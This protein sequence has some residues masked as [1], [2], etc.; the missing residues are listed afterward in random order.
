MSKSKSRSKNK[1]ED[2]IVIVDPAA[3]FGK[4]RHHWP[5]FREA[6]GRALTQDQIFFAE[7]GRPVEILAKE[8]VQNGVSTILVAGDD[9]TLHRV[10]NAIMPSPGSEEKISLPKIGILPG[11]SATTAF[12]SSLVSESRR[13]PQMKRI[14]RAVAV[15]RRGESMEVDLGLAEFV[16]SPKTRDRRYFLNLASFGVA[17]KIIANIGDIDEA[18]HSGLTVVTASIKALVK[19]RPEHLRLAYDGKP[20]PESGPILNFF[21]ANGSVGRLGMKLSPESEL[22][23]G[24]LRSVLVAYENPKEMMM[25]LPKLWFG[26]TLP[27]NVITRKAKSIQIAPLADRPRSR[28]RLELD[29]VLYGYVPARFTVAQRALEFLC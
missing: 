12:Y 7:S 9:T 21:V 6:F 18:I 24:Y 23:D 2:K 28:A 10:V 27:K 29:G 16:R 1:T 19:Y 15:I 3:D 14:E 4:M 11:S 25:E 5:F 17:D 8:A 20:Q 22:N 13:W 26:K